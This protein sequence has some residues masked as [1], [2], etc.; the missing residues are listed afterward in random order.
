M[1]NLLKIA[2]ILFL[3]TQISLALEPE[4]GYVSTQPAYLNSIEP[5]IIYHELRPGE[6]AED[7]VIVTNLVGKDTEF[8][9]YGTEPFSEENNAYKSYGEEMDNIGL[10]VKFDTDSHTLDIDEKTVI[11]FKITIPP[12]T[13]AG[14]YKGG[15]ATARLME[16]TGGP[17]NYSL[18]TVFPVTIVVTDNPQDVTY[19]P[20]FK[21]E[22]I[23][24]P[25]LFFYIT[26]AIFFACVIYI[27]VDRL[28]RK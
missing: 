27:A 4:G 20:K 26:L 1:K 16:S 22:T 14:T 8:S 25:T 15:L 28:K 24:E 6:E 18:R 23:K 19:E 7:A 5:A 10:W 9:L 3:T 13:P 11:P 17:I 21:T 2:F 12:D